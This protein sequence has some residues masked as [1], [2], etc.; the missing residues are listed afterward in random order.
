MTEINA[1]VNNVFFILESPL[2]NSKTMS[3]M[4]CQRKSVTVND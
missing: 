4:K 1:A 3:Q 2:F